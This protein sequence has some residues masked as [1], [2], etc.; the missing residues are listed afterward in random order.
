MKSRTRR[1]ECFIMSE[2]SELKFENERIPQVLLTK[3][4]LSFHKAANFPSVF[5]RAVKVG[6][7]CVTFIL[8]S[9]R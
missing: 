4:V 8:F 2:Q 7:G 3:K 5:R 1:V 6:E 9:H